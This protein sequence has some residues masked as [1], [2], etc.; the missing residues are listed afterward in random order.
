MACG[1]ASGPII[2]ASRSPRR[3]ALLRDA[4]FDVIGV[5]PSYDDPPEPTGSGDAETIATRLALRKAES[6]P[7]TTIAAYRHAMCLIA[8]DTITVDREGRLLGTPRTEDQARDM[9]RSLSGGS[10][11]VVT[12]VCV[13]WLADGSLAQFADRAEVLIH[14]LDD[15]TIDAHVASGA[16]RGKAGGYNLSEQRD[17]W[18]IRVVGDPSTVVGLPMQRVLGCLAEALA[19]A[20]RCVRVGQRGS[21]AQLG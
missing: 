13:R 18:R 21:H 16:W 12:G 19:D 20:P 6:I 11:S 9:L 2:L 8:A 17:R 15:A 7:F 14:R 1:F 4:G 5:R 10:H 3:L